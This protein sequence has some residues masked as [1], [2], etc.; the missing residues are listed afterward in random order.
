V[1]G[2]VA[3]VGGGLAGFVTYLTLRRGDVEAGQITVFA[4]E[5][6]PAAAWRRRAAAI[7]QTH[8]RSESDGHCLP[9]SFP[10]L[11][12]REARRRRSVA[13]LVRSVCDRYHPTVGHFL[14]HVEEVRAASGWS[15]CVRPARIERVRAVEDGFEL[16]DHGV[17]RH[18]M[19]ATGHPGN[20]MPE[21]LRE[22]PRAVHAYEPHD[23][24]ASVCVVGAGLAAATEWV[25]ALCTGA[26]VISVRRREPVRRPL[27]VP[28]P[29]LSRRRLA[30]FHRLAPDDRTALLREL[31]APSYPPGREWDEPLARASAEGRFQ[32]E[33]HVN[34]AEQVICA[35]GF[36]R[37]YR[38]D[39][40][41]RRLVHDHGLATADRWMVL[42]RDSTVPSL[43]DE[44]RT[45]AL[46][47]VQAQWAYPAADTLMGAR[48][49]AHAFLRKCR[50]H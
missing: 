2:R 1:S 20:A 34:G 43:T 48:Y 36:L 39:P 27:N 7:R 31:L 46:A 17:F 41:L 26:T 32:V 33:A 9:T 24:A 3:V 29:Y 14:E 45:L 35:T 42:D 13:P 10:G 19:L 15:E 38:H 16:D 11:A 28:R 44:T 22:D 23:Y 8:M 25:N 47:G 37:G 18:V 49:A 6:D 40:L 21:E 30:A 4:P 50:T 5:P 12:V